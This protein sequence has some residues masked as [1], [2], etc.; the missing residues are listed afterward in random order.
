[1]PFSTSHHGPFILMMLFEKK[2]T[3]LILKTFQLH[4]EYMVLSCSVIK[5]E[6]AY[7]MY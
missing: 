1:M 3:F 7:S 4:E 2:L 5:E 6:S